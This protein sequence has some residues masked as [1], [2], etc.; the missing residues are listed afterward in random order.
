MSMSVASKFPTLAIP[1]LVLLLLL[2]GS[3][4]ADNVDRFI[5]QLTTSKDSKVRVTA[6]T[7][8]ASLGGDRAIRAVIRALR[9]RDKSVRGVAAVSLAKL[10]DHE[11]EAK[12]R[13]DVLRALTTV[14]QRDPVAFVRQRAKQ[15][16]EQIEKPRPAGG[17]GIYVNI[18][19]MSAKTKGAPEK[20]RG[21]MRKAAQQ[22]FS[23]RASSMVTAWPS[24]REPSAKQLAASKTAGY[25]VDG[26][27][28]TLKAEPKGASTLVSCK[29]SMLLATYPDKSMF[30]F[31]DGG[32][33]VETGSSDRDIQYAQEDCVA[34]VIEN[35]VAKK[36][37]PAIQQRH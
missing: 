27:L 9:D 18:G 2:Q 1:V 15:A 7:G 6:V 20:I 33:R 28:L 8:L 5:K 22:T 37:I 10:V 17:G 21:L 29:I 19:A 13:K 31:L 35:L 26:T 12:L 30:G 24:G 25:H 32:A 36:I 14:A 4:H 16:R 23:K 11:T 3:A 34:A